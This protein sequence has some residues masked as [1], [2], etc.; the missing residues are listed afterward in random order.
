[1][2]TT[3][4]NYHAGLLPRHEIEQVMKHTGRCRR[5]VLGILLDTWLW[6][7]DQGQDG[8]VEG[9]G[10]WVL[11]QV[12]RDSDERFFAI[13]EHL[14]WLQEVDGNLVVPGWHPDLLTFWRRRQ[15][16]CAVMRSVNEICA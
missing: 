12:V 11:P 15:Q 4:I 7:K 6:I 5:D 14:G 1:M 16:L 10:L 13:L 9:V 8:V 2:R 3:T